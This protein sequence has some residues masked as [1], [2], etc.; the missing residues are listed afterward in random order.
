MNNSKPPCADRTRKYS[1]ALKSYLQQGDEAALH[2]AYEYGRGCLGEGR[3]ILDMVSMH[4]QAMEA[5]WNMMAP[6]KLQSEYF[7]S[8]GDFFNECM[9]PFEMTHRAFGEANQA[10]RHLNETLRGAGSPDWPGPS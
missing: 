3:S 1:A 10:L 9:S 4:H 8:A 6:S 7:R 2:H 5:V